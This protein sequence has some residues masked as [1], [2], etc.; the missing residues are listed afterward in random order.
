VGYY[1]RQLVETLLGLA[2]ERCRA[3]ERMAVFTEV[4]PQDK[5][6]PAQAN[7][8]CEVFFSTGNP[9][10]DAT[11]LAQRDERYGALHALT[12]LLASLLRRREGER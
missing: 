3:F 11:L 9:G 6:E 5:P 2:E 7:D 12:P 8:F 4:E 1:A 10:D